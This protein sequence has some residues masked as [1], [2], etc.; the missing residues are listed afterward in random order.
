METF[1]HVRKKYSSLKQC[2]DDTYVM[3]E[4]RITA[5]GVMY[6]EGVNYLL[7]FVLAAF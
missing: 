2:V 3:C 4:H 6:K 7:I 5:T 1:V